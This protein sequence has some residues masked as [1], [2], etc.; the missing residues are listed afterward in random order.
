MTVTLLFAAGAFTAGFAWGF[1]TPRRYC[2]LSTDQAK[3]FGNRFS[4]GLING[5]ILGGIVGVVASMAF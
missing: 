4:N 2:H 1:R 5:A 3:A